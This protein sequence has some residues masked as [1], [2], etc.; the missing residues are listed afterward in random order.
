M[1]QLQLSRCVSSRSSSVINYE[2]KERTEVS[3][4][5]VDPLSARVSGLYAFPCVRAH[6][7]A[8]IL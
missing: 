8:S 3:C 5:T 7:A 2:L 6:V 1:Q 4:V